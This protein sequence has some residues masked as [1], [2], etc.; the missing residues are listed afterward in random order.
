MYRC[1]SDADGSA[2]QRPIARSSTRRGRWETCWIRSFRISNV[3]PCGKQSEEL[4]GV[5][6]H[7]R[8]D[9]ARRSSS[10]GWPAPDN[11]KR[12]RDESRKATSGEGRSPKG[13]DEGKG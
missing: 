10:A 8:D 4:C 5:C 13:A 1:S 6:G 9:R 12:L 3:T 2:S 11:R 7:L